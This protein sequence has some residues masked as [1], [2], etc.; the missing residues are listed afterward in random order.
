M[1]STVL[2]LKNN[3]SVKCSRQTRWNNNYQFFE[4]QKM[5]MINFAEFFYSHT[6]NIFPVA[7][8]K[9]KKTVSILYEVTDGWCK[10]CFAL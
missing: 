1:L 5:T 8:K 4:R 7:W 9:K 3:H 6:W 10:R 2:S